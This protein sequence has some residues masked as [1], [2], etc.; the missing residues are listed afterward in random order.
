[1]SYIRR[2]RCVS[3]CV[4][5]TVCVRACVRAC[6]CVSVCV[7][8]CVRASTCVRWCARVCM[9]VYVLVCICVFVALVQVHASISMYLAT[10]P[11]PCA[12]A[13][14]HAGLDLKGAVQLPPDEDLNDWIAIHGQWRQQ[15]M[16]HCIGAP[17]RVYT[18]LCMYVRTYVHCSG[19]GVE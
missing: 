1:M 17:G 6:V 7:C 14:L 8:A 16:T 12:Q 4:C 2:Q 15:H 11:L 3:V 18:Y 9:R 5:V 13:S 10:C 19:L